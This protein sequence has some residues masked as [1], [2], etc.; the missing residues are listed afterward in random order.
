M[1]KQQS[2]KFPLLLS[3]MSIPL[4]LVSCSTID[5]DKNKDENISNVDNKKN[6]QPKK[7]ELTQNPNKNKTKIEEKPSEKDYDLTLKNNQ[8]N[9][10]FENKD[11]PKTKDESDLKDKQEQENNHNIFSNSQ[12][13]EQDNT[14]KSEINS[15]PAIDNNEKIEEKQETNSGDKKES[16][17]SKENF[18]EVSEQK[19]QETKDLT[20]K[21][22]QN[23]SSSENKNI[24][25]TK[26]ELDTKNQIENKEKVNQN[27]EQNNTFKS[28]ISSSPDIDNNEKLEEKQETNSSDKKESIESKEN[29]NTKI[30][31]ENA[32]EINNQE[33]HK[34]SNLV[35]KT[36]QISSSSEDKNTQETNENLKT[37]TEI[38]NPELS[39]NNLTAKE[40]QEKKDEN[41]DKVKS[42][43]E[44]NPYWAPKY[45][46]DK[47]IHLSTLKSYE[48]EKRRLSQYF[49]YSNAVP[50]GYYLE[51]GKKYEFQVTLSSVPKS[52]GSVLLYLKQVGLT[53]NSNFTSLNPRNYYLSQLENK[54]VVDLTKDKH[55]YAVFLS[56]FSNEPLSV[57]ITN[58][59]NE[60]SW[61]EYPFYIHDEDHPEL[62]WQ[63]IQKIKEQVIIVDGKDGK[64]DT[65]L[66]APAT[67]LQFSNPINGG[68]QI[69]WNLK[70]SISTF[71]E[72]LNLD[73]EQK[74][75]E[76]AK[77]LN[78]VIKNWVTELDLYN[79][80]TVDD[81]DELQQST[82]LPLFIS[83]SDTVV[84]PSSYYAYFNYIH[85]AP[86]L[87]KDILV[88]PMKIYDWIINHEKGHT[89][90]QQRIVI[91]EVTNN[92]YA[93]Y[94]S[95]L[96]LKK[97]IDEGNYN[98]KKDYNSVFN[99][100]F[101][102][103]HNILY[104]YLNSKFDNKPI[105]TPFVKKSSK[106]NTPFYPVYSWF[107]TSQF[108]NKL[109]YKTYDYRSSPFTEED[110]KILEK[111][112]IWGAVQRLLR[113]QKNILKY[114][115]DNLINKISKE[116]LFPYLFTIVSGYDFSDIFTKYGQD[117]INPD[118]IKFTSKYPK[119][120]KK[121]EYYN[122]NGELFW[123]ENKPAFN[124]DTKP[125]IKYEYSYEAIVLDVEF[126]NKTDID[127]AIAYELYVDGV[128]KSINSGYKIVLHDTNKDLYGK[129]IT[130]KAYDHKLNESLMSEPIIYNQ[131]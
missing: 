64:K 122:S 1:K 107:I 37:K 79:G 95:Y 8:N 109:D 25:D 3:S 77:N 88:E 26:E 104:R 106:N 115:S 31:K 112:G 72:K 114:D 94:A 46:E 63:Y 96:K 33:E 7:G 59:N 130:V 22:D 86:A 24:W 100:N 101:W 47:T 43:V 19:E 67:F 74:A 38:E 71:I 45:D 73:T 44:I 39:N 89:I 30:E 116:D 13:S 41:S 75:T 103:Q 34:D 62:F 57:K 110:A 117:D 51:A 54:I 111:Y 90:D 6:D 61:I 124:K 60:N 9:L 125:V 36:D 66:K 92:M 65:Q 21:N 97:L 126:E 2:K 131:K 123:L 113:D 10:S 120:D 32:N 127:S 82:N 18:N 108:V 5:D 42:K 35:S 68:L 28:E 105:N 17:E 83:A 53:E 76:Y 48:S 11:I 85:L 12:K 118:V 121:I 78:S 87:V 128:L 52:S 99:S 98:H 15:N 16:I 49:G 58:L 69:S 50:T 40:N 81:E 27:T 119:L 56:N 84:Q 20:S 70:W 14:S 55:G 23:I 80:L 93:L 91:L 102:T 129:K 29:S 4:I